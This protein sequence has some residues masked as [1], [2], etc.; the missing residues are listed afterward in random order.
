M[1]ETL[2]RVRDRNGAEEEPLPPNATWL[3][4]YGRLGLESLSSTAREIIHDDADYLVE[5]CIVP[6]SSVDSWSGSRSRTGL[7]VGAVQSG[8]TASMLAVSAGLLD[9]GLDILVVVAGT[10]IALWRQTY[11]RLLTQLDGTTSSTFRTRR[12]RRLIIPHP[13]PIMDAEIR[14]GAVTYM[15]GEV[16]RFREALKRRRPVIIVIPKIEDHLLAVSKFFEECLVEEATKRT[17]EMVILDDEADDGSVLDADI[18]KIIPRRIEMLWTGRHA[19]ETM[20]AKLFATYVAYTATPQAN[21]LQADH[22]PLAPRDFCAALRAPYKSGTRKPRRP[23]FL[24]PK[25]LPRYYCGGEF[26]YME[27]A[28]DPGDVVR[29]TR[30]PDRADLSEL[31]YATA[32]RH[33]LDML[34]MD[35]LRA[36]LVAGAIRLHDHLS[37][38]GLRHS[39]CIAGVAA[40]AGKRI[41]GPHSM[42]IHPSSKVDLHSGEAWRLVLLSRGVDPDTFDA[43]PFDSREL[44]LSCDGLRQHLEEDEGRW[45]AWKDAYQGTFDALTLLPGATELYE[46]SLVSWTDLKTILVDEIFPYVNLRIINS[47]PSSD[48]RPRFDVITNEDGT[49]SPPPDVLTVFVSGNVMSRGITIEG[50]HTSLFTRSASTPAADTQ[51][52]M[53]R[54]FGYRGGQAHLCRLFC[55]DDQLEL[56][57]TYHEH[58]T[59]L[60]TEVMAAMDREEPP[61]PK[62]ILT[63]ARSL[64]TAKIRTTRLPLHPGPSPFVKLVEVGEFA[65]HNARLVDRERRQGSWIELSPNSTVVGEIREETASLREVAALLDN[66]RYSFHDPDP[67][68]GV[69][70]TRWQSLERQLAIQEPLF[71]PPGL[72]PGVAA[73]NVKGCPFSIAAYLRLWSEALERPRCD[74]L[75]PTDAPEQPWALVQP[76][77]H[78][79]VFYIGIRYGSVA[80]SSWNS[81]GLL[82]GVRPM[83]RGVSVDELG[84]VRLDATWAS[85]GGSDGGYLGDQLMDYHHHGLDAPPLLGSGP[86][87]RRRGRPGLLLFQLIH[88]DGAQDGVA[89]G[90]ALPHGGPEHFAAVP[91][92]GAG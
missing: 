51:M 62:L 53:Q 91:A 25:G 2:I 81:L 28:D 90:L 92:G 39:E 17:V 26:F 47:D 9:R 24:E 7:V 19:N 77:L 85:R 14:P 87:W 65:E 16:S 45:E 70:F 84:A 23:T 67:A 5:K 40:S 60:R 32:V 83:A 34:A 33:S 12:K 82:H 76:T 75:Y 66:L 31:D 8:K 43:P 88:V 27:L 63:G 78:A 37:K 54:W 20:A 80:T 89:V 57:R 58:D 72:L 52:Q 10:R 13:A 29:A 42:L 6:P 44:T 21:F 4:R 48:D 61:S 68:G 49:V 36:Y 50:L 79:P 46:P 3:E 73:V 56:F 30:L 1:A 59:A 71:R 38:G 86:L 41:P 74:G 22:N 69:E 15:A 11:E 55:F 18:R 64:A 35:A